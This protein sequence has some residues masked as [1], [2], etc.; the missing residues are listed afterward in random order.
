MSAPTSTY[1]AVCVRH[2]TEIQT[3]EEAAQNNSP[4]TVYKQK[5][6]LMTYSNPPN[7]YIYK[8]KLYSLHIEHTALIYIK[9]VN[10]T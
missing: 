4:N 6:T 5:I 1:I 9:Y 8:K 3:P 7:I 10:L 2:E